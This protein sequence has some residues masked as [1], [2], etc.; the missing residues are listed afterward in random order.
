M[1]LADWLPRP[2]RSERS[3]VG[4]VG[5]AG[6]GRGVGVGLFLVDPMV[7]MYYEKFRRR[8]RR[9][10]NPLSGPAS[11]CGPRSSP[12]SSRYWYWFTNVLWW[13]IGP[14]FEI[15]G[16]LGVAWLLWRRDRLALAAALFPIAYYLTASRTVTPFARY[17]VVLVPALAV[18][19]G[20]F[21]ADLLAR[22]RWR[23][24][25][26]AVTAIVLGSTVLYAV[27]YMHVFAAPDSRL[28]ASKFL[29][30]TV[31]AGSSIL[32]E[33][34]HNIPPMGTYLT[35]PEFYR[36][37]VMWGAQTERRDYYHL[38]TLDTYRYLYSPRIDP[39]QKQAYIKARLALVNY[40]VM[41]DTYLQFYQH[42]PESEYGV[43]KQYCRDLFA[44]RLGFTLVRTFKVYPSLFGFE[45]NDDR[46]ELSFRLFDHPRV[47]IFKRAGRASGG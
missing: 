45:I 23:K 8:R 6:R 14:A 35:A 18:S 15:W 7:V 30:R 44:G 20:V 26:T 32:V 41:D 1:A 27:A 29:A 33:P 37:Y 28:M 11:R 4:G 25:A 31:P 39:A 9:V 2:G 17:G 21:S 36:D 12:A 42:L 16:L 47:F 19:A 3:P 43:V 22:P 5:G 13:G 34:S 10:T 38:Y 46:A 24:A 40:I